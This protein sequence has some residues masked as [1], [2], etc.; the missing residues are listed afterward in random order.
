MNS[1]LG[2]YSKK[3][4]RISQDKKTCRINNSN[5]KVLKPKTI[6]PKSPTSEIHNLECPASENFLYMSK[7]P[8]SKHH[9]YNEH[10]QYMLS[11]REYPG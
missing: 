5:L 1:N 2:P 10:V 4:E 8:Q 6:T 7:Y 11:S 3:L 9:K